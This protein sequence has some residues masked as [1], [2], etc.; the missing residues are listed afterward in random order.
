MHTSDDP[1][2]GCYTQTLLCFP[3]NGL[4]ID[5]RAAV[6]PSQIRA[7]RSLGL[8]SRFC[9][10][11]AHNPRGLTVAP[12]ENNERQKLLETDL[13][14]LGVQCVPCHG[15]DPTGTHT[16]A[17]V[18]VSI[19]PTEANRLAVRFEQSAFFLFDGS[20]FWLMPALV[21]ASPL[22]LPAKDGTVL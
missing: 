20:A 13:R 2:W 18:A 8:P 19:E 9:V 10:L 21:D 22:Q 7:Q 12:E 3:Q 16:E 17:G 5:L 4:V 11:T 14:S 15:S 6:Q 1:S